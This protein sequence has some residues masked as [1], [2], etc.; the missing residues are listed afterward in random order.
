MTAPTVIRVT[1]LFE[2]PVKSCRRVR[3]SK[4]KIDRFGFSRDRRWMIVDAKG[5]FL[6]QRELPR[7]ALIR[8]DFKAEKLFLDAPGKPRIAIPRP[9][10]GGHRFA[11][12]WDDK[13]AVA[14]VGDAAARWLTEFLEF[15]VRLVAMTPDHARAVDADYAIGDNYTSL[16]DGFPFLLICEESLIDLN[17]RLAAPLPINRFRPNIVVRGCEPY[18]EDHWRR[19]RIGRCELAVV[20]PC[21]RCAITTIDQETGERKGRE[22]LRAL[23]RYRSRFGEVVFGQNLIHLNPGFGISVGDVV[24]VLE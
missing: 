21:G 14:D 8:P 11:V 24:Q 19:I 20:K 18:A 23:G 22:P 16:A 13:V 17:T 6:T 3:T 5:V 9:D 7:M 10:A 2:Y 15:D 12:V 4:A 1:A